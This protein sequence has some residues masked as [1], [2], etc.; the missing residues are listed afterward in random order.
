MVVKVR[1][2]NDRWL[3]QGDILRDVEHIE[4]V[5]E[6]SGNLEISKIVFPLV[7][8]LS[9]D[10]DLS[11]DYKFRWSR[12]ETKNEDK[13][14]LSVLV[15][16]IYNIEHLYAG[17]HLADIGMRMGTL[18]RKKTEG[19][20][21]RNNEIPRYHYLEFPTDVP[22]VSSAI[23]FKHYFSV[24]VPY[25]KKLKKS[26]H[27]CRLSELYKEDVSQRF[28]SYLSRIGLP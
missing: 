10:C 26:N 14:L 6:L 24:N 4:Y 17:E 25:L 3:S 18:N 23:D 22:L 16:P 19:Q 2:T 15:A 1:Q 20:Y 8:V 13:W 11:Q 27:V 28:S 5:S 9:Q 21:L 12:K 7:I